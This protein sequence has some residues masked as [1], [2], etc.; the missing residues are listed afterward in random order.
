MSYYNDSMDDVQEPDD[1]NAIYKL[2]CTS[3]DGD[4]NIVYVDHEKDIK[5]IERLCW[6]SSFNVQIIDL[7][8]KRKQELLEAHGPAMSKV[9]Q[10]AKSFSEDQ[11]KTLNSIQDVE[12]REHAKKLIKDTL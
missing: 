8:E 3:P 4:I 1:E 9:I 7:V 12:L 5:E 11:N 2:I 6:I 10:A